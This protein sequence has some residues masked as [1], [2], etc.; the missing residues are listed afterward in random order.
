MCVCLC[1]CMHVCVCVCVC[2]CVCVCVY[3]CVRACVS[4]SVSVSVCVCLCMCMCVCGGGHFN[5]IHRSMRWRSDL[6]RQR[7]ES[8]SLQTY[9]ICCYVRTSLWWTGLKL[10]QIN[11]WFISWYLINTNKQ[12]NKSEEMH[13]ISM[14]YFKSNSMCVYYSK[15]ECKNNSKQMHLV[16]IQPNN[17]HH[18]STIA[19]LPRGDVSLYIVVT[20]AGL[21][22]AFRSASQMYDYI[23]LQTMQCF[24]I[25]IYILFNQWKDYQLKKYFFD[26]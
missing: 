25:Y 13:S 15:E 12:I 24:C 8:P 14:L 17:C 3:V 11:I 26:L 16:L 18:K 20:Q 6:S 4:V 10:N 2:E 1:V 21:I 22:G 23:W 19:S 7:V 9:R 5:Q